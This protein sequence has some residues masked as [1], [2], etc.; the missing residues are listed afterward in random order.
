MFTQRFLLFLYDDCD[1][2]GDTRLTLYSFPIRLNCLIISIRLTCLTFWRNICPIRFAAYRRTTRSRLHCRQS[3]DIPRSFLAN[4]HYV[5][6][7]L[8]SEFPSHD[9]RPA[10]CHPP[11]SII[12]HSPSSTHTHTEN[13][14]STHTQKLTHPEPTDVK[15][16]RS[17][18]PM[19]CLQ[20]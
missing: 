9:V 19:F 12:H 14:P 18:K 20:S 6:D 2:F 8:R 3:G 4:L 17:P 16:R 11:Q 5:P 13:Q 7:D 10:T 15:S 1:G